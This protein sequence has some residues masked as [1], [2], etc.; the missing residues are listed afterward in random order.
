MQWRLKIDKLSAVW[1]LLM[2]KSQY[3]IVSRPDAASLKNLV[4]PSFSFYFAQRW[5]ILFWVYSKR[6][7]S[8]CQGHKIHNRRFY[9]HALTYNRRH[10]GLQA[11]KQD[12]SWCGNRTGS[13]AKGAICSLVWIFQLGGSHIVFKQM[14]SSHCLWLKRSW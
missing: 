3:C 8:Y 13:R 4:W 5:Y 12:K 11:H 7:S 2:M 6:V 14:V 9:T 1:R 10:K